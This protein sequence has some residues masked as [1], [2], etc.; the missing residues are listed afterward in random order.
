MPAQDEAPPTLTRDDVIKVAML[1]RLALSDTE[2]SS[3]TEELS[4]IVGFVSQLS[5]LDTDEVE[6]LAH[7]LDSQ[8]VFREDRPVPSLTTADALR[9][10]PRHDEECFLVPAVLGESGSA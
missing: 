8:N 4:K 7:P 10:A 5:E 3:L 2:L 1:A 9:C 6:P